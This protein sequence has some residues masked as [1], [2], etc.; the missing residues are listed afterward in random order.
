M[1]NGKADLGVLFLSGITGLLEG[2]SRKKMLERELAAESKLADFERQQKEK[3]AE[4][5]FILNLAQ[6][7]ET[8]KA[9]LNLLEE[10]FGVPVE[11]K[12]KQEKQDPVNRIMEILATG[13]Q[14]I[15]QFP[16]FE[17]QLADP[18]QPARIKGFT[19]ELTPQQ[20]ELAI[21]Q[22]GLR[23]GLTD[24]TIERLKQTI[25]GE[26]EKKEEPP[27]LTPQEA[28]L[29]KERLAR[30]KFLEAQAKRINKQLDE[31]KDDIV[32]AKPDDDTLEKAKRMETFVKTWLSYYGEPPDRE[33]FPDAWKIF[34]TYLK[35]LEKVGQEVVPGVEIGKKK[36]IQWVD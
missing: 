13:G 6:L 2:I 31:K 12:I 32:E 9:A 21:E 8:R 34:N 7:P 24:K 35:Y 28:A 20:K 16:G 18:T 29:M 14:P 1:A 23:F 11:N 26:K 33:E 30:A 3:K 22:V 17:Q 19:P 15:M 5:D 4:L 10:R 27:A 36:K 25:L